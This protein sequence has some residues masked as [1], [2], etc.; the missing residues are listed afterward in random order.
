MNTTGKNGRRV[1]IKDIAK[2]AG[3]SYATV[4]RALSEGRPIKE[5]TRA[6]ILEVCERMGYTTNYVA[7]SMVMGQS[8]LL[9]IIIPSINNPFMSEVAYHIELYAR[10]QG[11][12]I[13]L[14]NSSYDLELEAKT[15][16][17]LVGRQVDG[18]LF[19]PSRRESYQNIKK[20][21]SQVPTV[22]VNEDLTTKPV[23]CIA[24]DNR[25]G[26]RLGVEYL[27]ELGHRNILYLGR[28]SAS[29]TH[30]QRALGYEEACREHGIAPLYLDSDYQATTIETGYE[31][32]LE[33]F[34]GNLDYTAIMASADTLALGVLQA[35]DEMGIDIP[36]QVSLLGFD[37][38]RYAALPKI[39]LST[40]EQPKQAIA[41][42]AV[43]MLL[44]KAASD[45]EAYSHRILMPTLIRR[46]SCAPPPP[47]A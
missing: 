20:H 31:M 44:E 46:S 1:T 12:N 14:C 9:G 23:S 19:F 10:E 39:K 15:F 47:N 16:D 35:A 18:I 37:N 4:S 3:V 11:Y 43:D 21:L 27:L 38:I 30:E 25:L 36:G 2:E 41:T 26:S 13:M 7:R 28:Q 22:F 17:L 34:A 24:T 45:Y 40:I 32:A 42:V 33:L 8:Q 6:K 29:V 5:E